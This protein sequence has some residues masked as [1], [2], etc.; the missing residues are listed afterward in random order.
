MPR[1]ITNLSPDQIAQFK[2]WVEKW[3]AVGLSTE[4]ADFDA[5]ETAALK[6]YDLCGLNARR[7]AQGPG[8]ISA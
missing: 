4:P 8:L 5:A 2:P 7:L 3:V 6:A 1:K